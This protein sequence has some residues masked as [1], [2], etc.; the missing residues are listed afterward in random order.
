MAIMFDLILD[1][2]NNLKIVNGDLAIEQSDDQN[3]SAILQAK[4]GQFYQYPLLGY[5]IQD[6]LNGPFIKQIEKKAIRQELRRDDY[7][8][9]ELR[10]EDGPS[11]FVD[12][13]KRK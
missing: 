5:G 2:T 4:K 10:I 7:E 12:A 13:E 11:V 3:I 6:K 8:V 9:I 1:E